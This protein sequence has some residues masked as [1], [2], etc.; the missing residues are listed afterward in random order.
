[1]VVYNETAIFRVIGVLVP[2]VAESSVARIVSVLVAVLIAVPEV[3][4]FTDR[5]AVI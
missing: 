1:M 4:N 3:L 2:G 5:S